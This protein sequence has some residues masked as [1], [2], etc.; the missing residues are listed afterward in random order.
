MGRS[1]VRSL[2]AMPASA[3]GPQ[4]HG[5]GLGMRLRTNW[6]TGLYALLAGA[7][8]CRV[9]L[10]AALV[11]ARRD[12]VRFEE[13]LYAGEAVGEGEVVAILAGRG[14]FGAVGP[15]RAMAGGDVAASLRRGS[16]RLDD[17][18]IALVPRGR[19]LDRLLAGRRSLR[20]GA[21]VV[22]VTRQA[23]LDLLVAADADGLADRATHGLARERPDFC[24]AGGAAPWQRVALATAS[25]G[26]GAIVVAGGALAASGLIALASLVFLALAWLRLVSLMAPEARPA[27]PGRRTPDRLLPRYTVLVPLR[28]ESAALSGL[29]AALRRLDYPRVKLDIKFLVEAGDRVTLGTLARIGQPGWIDLVRVPPGGPTTKPRALNVGL[30]LAR[31]SYTVVFDA[32]DRPSPG[33]LRAALATFREA[34]AQLGVV[35]AMLAIDPRQT[36]VL[37]DQFRMEYAGHFAVLLPGLEAIGLPMPLG[38]TSNHFRTATLRR[39]GG[40]DAFNVT[41]D[42]DLGLRLARLGYRAR[43]MPELTIEEAP[44]HPAAWLRQRTRWLK[45]WMVTTMVHGRHPRALVRELGLARALGTLLLAGG[46]ALS[47]L[48]EPPCLVMVVVQAARG[49]LHRDVVSWPD[50]I[51]FATAVTAL[52]VGHGAAVLTGLRGLA[53]LGRPWRASDVLM[54]PGYWLLVSLAAWRALVQAVLAPSFWDKTEHRQ[55]RMPACRLT[56]RPPGRGAGDPRSLPAVG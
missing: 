47:A 22:L 43:V 21:G 19:I 46:T 4:P 30:A 53:R 23:M 42:M 11:R 56:L 24:A 50:A 36:G 51:L 3:I 13:A 38:G 34:G 10:D 29:I 35:Q 27:K 1:Q 41:E 49:G 48:A 12:G 6:G 40:W 45:G 26:A 5:M 18:R 8:F 33:Q 14:G 37:A 16:V 7:G 28:H 32:E 31:G 20:S 54:L 44:A 52:A 17:G 2:H 25:F 55:V 39:C 15:A 9:S